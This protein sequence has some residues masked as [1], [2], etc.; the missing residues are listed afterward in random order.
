[1]IRNTTDPKNKKK[2]LCVLDVERII[3]T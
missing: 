3:E 2:G 1:M